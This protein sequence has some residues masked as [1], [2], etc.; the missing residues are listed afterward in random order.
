MER[1][2]LAR[3]AFDI[4]NALGGDGIFLVPSKEC[5]KKLTK[6]GSDLCK[7]YLKAPVQEMPELRRY[8]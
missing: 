1:T 5:Y 2:K 8:V 7:E 3:S 6:A 4:S